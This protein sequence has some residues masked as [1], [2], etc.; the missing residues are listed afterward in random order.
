MQGVPYHYVCMV[1]LCDVALWGIV[2]NVGVPGPLGPLEW[3]SQS[4]VTQ[5]FEVNVF[6][7]CRVVRT[8]LPLLKQS[9]SRVV[10]TSSILGR[11]NIPFAAPY[12]MTKCLSLIHI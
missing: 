2:N 6:G 1:Y 11:L 3:L 4:D 9:G 7:M 8:F 10:N 12:C 5:L